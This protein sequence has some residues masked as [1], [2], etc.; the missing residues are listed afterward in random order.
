MTPRAATRLQIEAM[1]PT[2]HVELVD[3]GSTS[4]IP[5][6]GNTSIHVQGMDIVTSASVDL[7]GKQATVAVSIAPDEALPVLVAAIKE[8][9][10]E[11]EPAK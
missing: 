10:F 3:A 7:E 2:Q 8:L 1:H 4:V 11:A 5:K 6:N 9:G